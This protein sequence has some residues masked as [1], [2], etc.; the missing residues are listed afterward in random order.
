MDR[1][2]VCGIG[3]SGSI[4]GESTST[5]KSAPYRGAFFVR[6]LTVTVPAHSYV[7]NRK[8]EGCE[9]ANERDRVVSDIFSTSEANMKIVDS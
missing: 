9:L 3:D 4:P 2:P 6:A 7:R 1:M 5:K 8:S